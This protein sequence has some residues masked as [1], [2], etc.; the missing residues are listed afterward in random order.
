[1]LRQPRDTSQPSFV[2][3]GP[4]NRRRLARKV[5]AMLTPVPFRLSLLAMFLGAACGSPDP[6]FP[7][8]RARTPPRSETETP[9]TQVPPVACGTALPG[10]PLRAELTEAQ[11]GY[12]AELAA[13]DLRGVPDPIDYS[14]ASKLTITLINYM[15]GRSAGTQIPLPTVQ[16]HGGLGQA[17]LGA[18][19]K[20]TD[21]R[22]DFPFLRR[23][24]HYFYPCS[25]PLPASLVD[26]RR[27][28]G[29]Y[30]IWPSHS[31]ECSRAKNAPRRIYEEHELG[32]YVAET[33]LDGRVRETEVLF[34]SLRTDG[35]LD[36]AVYTSDGELSDRSTFAA[37]GGKETVGAAPYTCISCHLDADRG[38][39]ARLHPTGT[40]AGCR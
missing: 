31:V 17:I 5:L 13:L 18:W 16:Q 35:Q 3:P 8:D 20:G 12:A 40:G 15:L 32:V 24:L 30:R 11:P 7:S 33:L 2:R 34:S 6:A 37:A 25:R 9:P 26:L 22:P 23:G 14:T 4:A 29:N 39:I 38:T 19:A 21:G 28:Y 10:P 1:M 36:F 27:L